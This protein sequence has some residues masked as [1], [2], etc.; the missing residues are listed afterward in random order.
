M[1]VVAVV[2][3]KVS[4]NRPIKASPETSRDTRPEAWP[5]L[6]RKIF[7]FFA[8][9]PL[10]ILWHRSANNTPAPGGSRLARKRKAFVRSALAQNHDNG[11]L[12][13]TTLRSVHRVQ[14][15]YVGNFVPSN[16]D[17]LLEGVIKYSR[18]SE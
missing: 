2:Q 9:G 17:S 1:I 15:H 3:L 8:R 11:V 13:A 10:P 6:R 14:G 7:F 18:H 16:G 12:I 5:R 4:E